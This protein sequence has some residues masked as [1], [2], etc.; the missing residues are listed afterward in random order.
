[1]SDPYGRFGAAVSVAVYD[2]SAVLGALQLCASC[3][4]WQIPEGDAGE[5][6]DVLQGDDDDISMSIVQDA[7]VDAA[8]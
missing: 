3:F 1:M 6:A 5:L 8:R 7:N 2:D 4:A